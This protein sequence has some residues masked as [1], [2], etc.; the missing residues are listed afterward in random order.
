MKNKKTIYWVVAGIG[1]YLVY[2]WWSKKQNA[3]IG[4]PLQLGAPDFQEVVVPTNGENTETA[5]TD[6]RVGTIGLNPIM[7]KG[8]KCYQC[9]PDTAFQGMPSCDVRVVPCRGSSSLF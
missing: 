3:P 8:K 7:A 1:A 9:T 4:P 6:A 2:R 5:N